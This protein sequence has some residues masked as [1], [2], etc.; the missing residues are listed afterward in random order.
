MSTKMKSMWPAVALALVAL[1]VAALMATFYS[2]LRLERRD[3]AKASAQLASLDASL[4]RLQ[5]VNGTDT[6]PAFATELQTLR[7]R[8]NADTAAAGRA[9]ALG[10]LDTLTRRIVT[11]TRRREVDTASVSSALKNA[12]GWADSLRHT[13]ESPSRRSV[14]LGLIEIV[15][16]AA[17]LLFA[18]P[19]LLAAFIG[20]VVLSRRGRARF[21]EFLS[22]FE[23]IKLFSAE[24]LLTSQTKVN[25][26]ETLRRL[27]AQVV[28]QYSRVAARH[29]VYESLEIVSQSVS[30]LL[31]EPDVE[32]LRSRI[33]ELR[34]AVSLVDVPTTADTG[35]GN[36]GYAAQAQPR[37]SV[38]GYR[39]TVY[40]PDLLFAQHLYQ[41][42]DYS[43]RGSKDRS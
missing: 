12:K 21:Q 5:A 33:G 36:P 8:I 37:Q 19:V 31:F 41:L 30:A 15:A 6:V 7:Q 22:P 32:A 17:R 25:A 9:G 3:W 23:S 39:C 43:P 26:E 28:D 11:A 2:P 20:V 34:P 42:V 16:G 35:S 1:M 38:D 13:L 10:A 27:R 24:L 14:T 29:N 18:W 40:V 4:R